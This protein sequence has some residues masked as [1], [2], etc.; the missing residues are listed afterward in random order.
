[1]KRLATKISSPLIFAHVR[2]AYPG[3]L[4]SEANSHPF[5]RGKFLWMHN[6]MLYNT[7]YQ[8]TIHVATAIIAITVITIII[9]INT[10]NNLGRDH[11]RVINSI[12]ELL[13]LNRWDRGFP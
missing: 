8:I 1:M 12:I 4:V 5:Q 9:A 6:G 2:A 11:N 13:Y 7:K 10:Q 3:M